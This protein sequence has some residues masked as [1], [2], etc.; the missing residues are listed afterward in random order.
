MPFF[1]NHVKFNHPCPQTRINTGLFVKRQILRYQI[2]SVCTQGYLN[3]L[4]CS[5]P[6]WSCAWSQWGCMPHW[7]S[8]KNM[9][10]RDKLKFRSSIFSTMLHFGWPELI[11]LPHPL[12]HP[13]LAVFP[14]P[15]HPKENRRQCHSCCHTCR[16]KDCIGS[17]CAELIPLLHHHPVHG[18][19]Q[20]SSRNQ[21]NRCRD[22]K[23]CN[24]SLVNP[25]HT[26]CIQSNCHRWPETTDIWT[27]CPYPDYK[28]NCPWQA[29]AKSRKPEFF[30]M[31]IK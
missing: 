24:R 19:V 20:G 4:G 14:A 8:S 17:I 7:I 25:C 1:V 23:H 29:P 12:S 18:P 16:K 9:S 11:F 2:I 15:D 13:P 10:E 3:S 27:G 6:S 30:S 26:F 5:C 28:I 22:K 31:Y 21:R